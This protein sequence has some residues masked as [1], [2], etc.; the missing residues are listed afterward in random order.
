M[1]V[2]IFLLIS[3]YF[4]IFDYYEVSCMV[5]SRD[6]EG[7]IA[8]TLEEVIFEFSYMMICLMEIKV[9]KR[10]ITR[11]WWKLRFIKWYIVD[12]IHVNVDLHKSFINTIASVSNEENGWDPNKLIWIKANFESKCIL[13]LV[14]SCLVLIFA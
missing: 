8:C 14:L 3:G 11:L 1:F 13:V 4:E 7:E 2:L 5:L 12:S 9:K 6:W 10:K